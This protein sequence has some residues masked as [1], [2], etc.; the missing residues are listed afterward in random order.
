M[1][2]VLVNNLPTTNGQVWSCI[3]H[4]FIVNRMVPFHGKLWPFAKE[5]G[6]L[7]A[8]DGRRRFLQ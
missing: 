7:S 4:Y 2:L 8:L 6:E 3:T 1:K 5:E